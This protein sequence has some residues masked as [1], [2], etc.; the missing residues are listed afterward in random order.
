VKR[1]RVE[2]VVIVDGENAEFAQ[3]RAAIALQ[4]AELPNPLATCDVRKF[5]ITEAR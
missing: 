4:Y 5:E 3:Q 1:Y 2:F